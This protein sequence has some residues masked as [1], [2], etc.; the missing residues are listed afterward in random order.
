MPYRS[1]CVNPWLS[2]A[3]R[4]PLRVAGRTLRQT[5]WAPSH[6]LGGAC[7]SGAL[8][9]PLPGPLARPDNENNP[10]LVRKAC[11][12]SMVI[13]GGNRHLGPN[14]QLPPRPDLRKRKFTNFCEKWKNMHK[15]LK[16][17]G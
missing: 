12:Q 15:S 14:P 4:P 8:L 5:L 6:R 7:G 17:A 3:Y 13:T 16:K 10:L 11:Q 9:A 1:G 2:A